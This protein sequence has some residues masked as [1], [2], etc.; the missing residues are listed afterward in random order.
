MARQGNDGANAFLWRRLVAHT[1]I[2]QHV[3]PLATGTSV[4]VFQMLTEVI[5]AKEL[6][7][8]VAF[9]KFV[10]VIE[11]FRPRFPVSRVRE[12]FTTVTANIGY[13][14]PGR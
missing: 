9:S 2:F 7:C 13:S 1:C 11:M 5:G 12:L 8:L 10:H 4:A 6:L 3:R 14:W